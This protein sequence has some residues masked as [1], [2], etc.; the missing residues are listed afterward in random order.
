MYGLVN[1]SIASLVCKQFGEN[2]WERVQQRAG[3]E[4]ELF[5]S[6][7]SYPDEH[8]YQLVGAACEELGLEAADFLKRLGEH[9]VLCTAAESYGDL[10]TAGGSSLS[11][12]LENL[13]DFHTRIVMI[14]PALCPPR[15]EVSHRTEKSLR[16]HYHSSRTGLAPFVCG[17]LDGLAQRFHEDVVVTHVAK[18]D[19]GASHDEF[20]IEW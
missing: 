15:F 19:D 5:V 2:V 4:L 14:M 3:L 18:R 17:L 7:Q 6:N 1:N 12:F 16:L 9:W 10:L 20:Q 8:T 13:P 11:E